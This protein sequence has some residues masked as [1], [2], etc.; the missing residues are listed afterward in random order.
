M[1]TCERDGRRHRRGKVEVNTHI[2]KLKRFVSH[3]VSW[4]RSQEQKPPLDD[5]HSLQDGLDFRSWISGAVL[6]DCTTHCRHGFVTFV[7]SRLIRFHQNGLLSETTVT[8][9]PHYGD[10]GPVFCGSAVS[11]EL[12]VGGGDCQRRGE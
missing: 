4:G 1:R 12:S 9:Y 3:V 7:H 2:Q 10:N 5:I 11:D 8:V 6:P